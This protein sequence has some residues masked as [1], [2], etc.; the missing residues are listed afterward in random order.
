[1]DAEAFSVRTG[2]AMPCEDADST[3][4]PSCID[5]RVGPQRRVLVE[6]AS[7]GVGGALTSLAALVDVLSTHGYEVRVMASAHEAAAECGVL[8]LPLQDGDGPFALRVARRSLSL[9]R[10]A[11]AWRPHV[12]LGNNAPAPNLACA[13]AARALGIPRLQYVRGAFH[14]GRLARA[15]LVDAAAIFAVGAEV[16]AR[17]PAAIRV[18]EGLSEAQ[19]PSAREGTTTRRFWCSTLAPW[20]GIGLFCDALAQAPGAGADLCAAD[21][22]SWGH[23]GSMAA[24]MPPGCVVHRNASQAS[25]DRLRSQCGIYVH[26]ALQ[27]EPFGRSVLEAMAAGLCPVV[28][29][30]GGPRTLVTHGV[31]GL[32]Y[33]ARSKVSLVAA[34]R[35]LD[36]DASLRES[37]SNEAAKVAHA[38]RAEVAFEPIRLALERV[39][40]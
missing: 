24:S 40:W 39:L 29:D 19:W 13:I 34:L 18:E 17:L 38:H 35:R 4:P 22:A 32:H 2:A 21:L 14:R 26:T 7:P 1:M 9:I 27:P 8:A 16:H 5:D 37:L 23:P 25:I 6:D 15:V 20:K 36:A 30:E 28:P 12:L 11:R 3:L 10:E 31:S 33:E